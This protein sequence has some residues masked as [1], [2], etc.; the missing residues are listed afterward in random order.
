MN[1]SLEW[2]RSWWAG[3]TVVLGY[4]APS[5]D[6]KIGKTL[7]EG[8]CKQPSDISKILIAVDIIRGPRIRCINH[9]NWDYPMTLDLVN[10]Q[11]DNWWYPRT[12]WLFLCPV[13]IRGNLARLGKFFN[14]KKA[15]A[16]PHTKT[17]LRRI[18]SGLTTLHASATNFSTGKFLQVS[19]ERKVCRRFAAADWSWLQK[20]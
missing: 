18:M 8:H 4:S 5:R 9:E 2:N 1:Y 7:T 16:K 13:R 11:P 12:W 17:Y 14:K 15:K 19:N 3:R 10:F 6:L 20:F